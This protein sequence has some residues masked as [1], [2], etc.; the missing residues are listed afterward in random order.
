MFGG[1]RMRLDIRKDELQHRNMDETQGIYVSNKK[2]GGGYYEVHLF[3]RILG[4]KQAGK[5][6]LNKTDTIFW[7]LFSIPREAENTFMRK[8]VLIYE[9]NTMPAG[10]GLGSTRNL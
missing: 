6:D 8:A 7:V 2:A 10:D 5:I 1:H 4:S 3:K 9:Y